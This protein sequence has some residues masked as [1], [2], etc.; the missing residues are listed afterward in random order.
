MTAAE[1]ALRH[2]KHVAPFDGVVNRREVDPGTLVQVGTPLFELVQI[3]R[4]KA[5]GRI[6]QQS[7]SSVEPGQ[8]VEVKLLDGIAMSGVVG[9]VAMA[10]S[11]ETRRFA[12]S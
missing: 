3:D 8:A 11:S 10:A 4:L 1:L 7:V 6:P 9:F 5:T 2:L 12:V